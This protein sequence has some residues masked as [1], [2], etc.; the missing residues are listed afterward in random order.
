MI[1]VIL[2][3]RCTRC[4]LCADV[5]PTNVF[6]L[7]ADRTPTIARADDCQTCFMCELYCQADA[8]FVAPHCDHA[9]TVSAEQARAHAGR[10][11]RESGWDEWAGD[12]LY[13]NEHWRMD[14][15]FARARDAG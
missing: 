14:R 1:E 11:R 13:A 5:C 4:G 7:A 9:V 15:V 12:P 3:D 6:D 2:T 8:L 10:F